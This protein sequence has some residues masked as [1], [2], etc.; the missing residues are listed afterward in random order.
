MSIEA[1]VADIINRASEAMTVFA[2]SVPESSSFPCWSCL[3]CLVV[4]SPP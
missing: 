4:V 2:V 1:K 3:V